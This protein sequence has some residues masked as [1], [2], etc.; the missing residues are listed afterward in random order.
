M[1]YNSVILVGVIA[2]TTIWWIVQGAKNYPGPRLT[3]LYILE[4]E[5]AEPA[6]AEAQA[7]A[8]AEVQTEVQAEKG[9]E[10]DSEKTD[11]SG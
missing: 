8:Q 11:P 1:N 10:V 3:H 4:G 7:E 9:R 5:A 2:L 6:K